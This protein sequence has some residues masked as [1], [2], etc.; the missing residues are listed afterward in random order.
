MNEWFKLISLTILIISNLISFIEFLKE[1]LKLSKY[2]IYLFT[3]TLIGSNAGSRF[4]RTPS[5]LI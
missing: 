4:F 2:K 5:L 1:K 3:P